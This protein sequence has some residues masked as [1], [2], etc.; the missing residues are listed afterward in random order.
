MHLQII[1]KDGSFFTK[2]VMEKK[3]PRL[4]ETC[5]CKTISK[6]LLRMQCKSSRLQA[7]TSICKLFFHKKIQM[8]YEHIIFNIR[9]NI[10]INKKHTIWGENDHA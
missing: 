9:K 2:N 3:C 8:Y 5:K 10:K 6:C 1:H 4:I 7:M